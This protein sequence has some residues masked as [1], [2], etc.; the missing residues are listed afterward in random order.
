MRIS[1]EEGFHR[2]MFE[3]MLAESSAVKKEE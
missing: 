1:I 3:A 2:Q